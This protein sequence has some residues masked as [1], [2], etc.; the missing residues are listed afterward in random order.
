MDKYVK[1]TC[2][3]GQL[4][5]CCAFLVVGINGFECAKG[6]S[7][8]NTIELRLAEGT[9]TATGDNCPGGIKLADKE[10]MT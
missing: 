8:Q 1:E 6:T 2:K 5:N 3:I 9:M 7:M 10:K 4:H